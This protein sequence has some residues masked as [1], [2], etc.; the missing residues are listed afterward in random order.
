[1]TILLTGSTS[2]IGWETLKSLY[3]QADQWILPLRNIRKAED[4]FRELPDQDRLKIYEMDLSSIQQTHK[5]AQEIKSNHPSI[6]ILINNAG[7]MFPGGKK[8]SEGFDMT[9]AVN[10]LGPFA[11]TKQLLPCLSRGKSKVIYVSSE[12]HRIPGLDLNDLL[13]ENYSS[14]ITAYGAVKLFNILTAKY[15]SEQGYHTYALHPGAVKTAFGAETDPIS[16]AIIRAT[17]LF[18]ISPRKGAETTIHLAKNPTKNL[19]SGA[20]YVRKKVK[21]PSQLARSKSLSSK[22]WNQSEE[23]LKKLGL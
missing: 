21:K 17:Q 9:F 14:T 16:K 2:G 12:A 7:G 6:D 19:E 20:Y 5:I 8:T 13:L 4:L 11:L 18:F 3:D 1:M 22:L 15:L 23:A 10:H